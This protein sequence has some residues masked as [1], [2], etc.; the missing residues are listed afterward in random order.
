MT[1]YKYCQ[2]F[3][4]TST[5]G[6]STESL[7]LAAL[8]AVQVDNNAIMKICAVIS[9]PDSPDLGSM[10]FSSAAFSAMEVTFMGPGCYSAIEQVEQ[11]LKQDGWEKTDEA[12]C[13]RKKK[14]W[15]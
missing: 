13:Y 11:K 3:P 10:L 6:A 9:T 8:K 14:G 1:S 15:W 2:L 7:P 4:W 12:F 5:H